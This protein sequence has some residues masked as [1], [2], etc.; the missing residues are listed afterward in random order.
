[1]DMIEG[2]TVWLKSGGSSMTLG[3]YHEATNKWQ[4]TWFDENSKLQGAR[5]KK[6]ML[7]DINPNNSG[8]PLMPRRR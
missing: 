7:T 5:F 2:T 6:E 8:A 3:A 1:M 4:C